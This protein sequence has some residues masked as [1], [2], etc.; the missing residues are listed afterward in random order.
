M[1]KS[2]SARVR[3][4]DVLKGLAILG[5]MVQHAFPSRS[6]NA[7]WD[8]LHVGQAVPIFFIIMGLN[9]ARSLGRH[10]AAPLRELYS[11]RYLRGRFQ[12]LIVPLIFMWLLAVPVAIAAG[13]L[14][15]GPLVLLGAYPMSS[16]PGNYF[17]TITVEFALLFP[18]LFYCF[19]RAPMVTTVVVAVMDVVFELVAPHIHALTPAGVAG[20]YL[21][22]AGIFKYGVAIVAG[23]WLWRRPVGPRS[24][25]ILTPLAA[26]SLLYLIILHQSPNDFSWLM[27]SFSRSTNFLSVF[28]ALWLTCLGM[29]LISPR[30]RPG[31]SRLVERLGEASY[32]IFLV[33]IIW[34]GAV[35]DRSLVVGVAGIL[36]SSVLGLVYF[37]V[38]SPG[39]SPAQR[40]ERRRAAPAAVENRVGDREQTVY[41]RPQGEPGLDV[42]AGRLSEAPGSVRVGEQAVDGLGQSVGIIGNHQTGL[43]V[44]DVVGD[45]RRLGDDDGLPPSH[46]VE[47]GLLPGAA[48]GAGKKRNDDDRRLARQTLM[49]VRLEEAGPQVAGPDLRQRQRCG[50]RHRRVDPVGRARQR[51]VV[52]QGVPAGQ[53]A[54]AVR[55]VLQRPGRGAERGEVHP[56]GVD[57]PHVGKRLKFP[58][59]ENAVVDIVTVDTTD[60]PLRQATPGLRRCVIADRRRRSAQPV[61]GAAARLPGRVGHQHRM[62]PARQR[63]GCH[64][65]DVSPVKAGGAVEDGRAGGVDQAPESRRSPAAHVDLDRALAPFRMP[66]MAICR[67][68]RAHR[69]YPGPSANSRRMRSMFSGVT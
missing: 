58:T 8:T 12:R 47:V 41:V 37:S 28:Y 16:A 21:Y 45:A 56:G 14:H 35:A 63:P 69:T 15:I 11:R 20:G 33:Q 10:E 7:A 48:L 29:W 22:E 66:R 18:A 36:I 39:R 40:P 46:G 3:Q 32:H 17:V 67:R 55:R 68:V 49:R 30:S 13:N 24:L 34:F 5:V 44:A 42:G 57:V 53:D 62:A 26:A 1:P 38:Q 61:K 27:N 25:R 65:V 52:P 23:M 9:A 60:G 19:V 54:A 4:I 31:T 64:Q 59:G 50:D 51:P 43:A 6:L 2:S